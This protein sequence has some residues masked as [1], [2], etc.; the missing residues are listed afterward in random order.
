MCDENEVLL[1]HF[2]AAVRRD[3]IAGLRC[4]RAESA[5]GKSAVAAG[6]LRQ[7]WSA[8]RHCEYYG[9]CNVH[10]PQRGVG[11]AQWKT[12]AILPRNRAGIQREPEYR[13]EDQHDRGGNRDFDV[14]RARPD[15]ALRC[16]GRYSSPNTIKRP[17]VYRFF[18]PPLT[19][20]A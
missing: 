10:L 9:T 18:L 15:V 1:F 11:G 6:D 20:F 12:G 7:R 17:R 13:A 14:Q 16:A 8:S 4:G 19:L 3:F 2:V 5:A